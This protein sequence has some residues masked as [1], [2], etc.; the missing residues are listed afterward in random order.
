MTDRKKYY[1]KLIKESFSLNEV[2][3]KANICNTTGNYKTLKKIIEEEKIDTSH[4]KRNGY[5]KRSDHKRKP[6]EEYLTIDSTIVSSRLKRYLLESGI[7]ERKCERCGNTTWMGSDIPI[8]LHH[9]NGNNTDNRLENLQILCSNCHSQTENFSG[10]NQKRVQNL[11]KDKSTKEKGIEKAEIAKQLLSEGKTIE[12]LA[13]HFNQKKDSLIDFLVR[14]GIH[15]KKEK[16]KTYDINETLSLL[17][18][19]RSFRRV[20]K[21]LGISDKSVIKRLKTNKLP[22][23]IKDVL[24]YLDNY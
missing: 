17:K 23:K 9:I 2:C 16:K 5:H 20:A 1:I 8:E 3:R 18:E 13:L 22:C 21:I 15:V 24:E 6:I 7:K 19:Y 12:E 4:F 14:H 11:K 10:K